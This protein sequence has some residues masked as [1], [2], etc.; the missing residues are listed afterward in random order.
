[1]EFS[2]TDRSHFQAAVGTVASLGDGSP[3]VDAEEGR[4]QIRAGGQGS[5]VLVEAVRRLDAAGVH[6]T[7]LAL[8]RPS[9]DDVFMS[10][11]GHVAED[12]VAAGAARGRRANKG[13]GGGDDGPG[14]R[15]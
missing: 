14:G 1:V 5:Q 4:V 8:R 11:T 9:L 10:L 2:V 7:G 6:T 12:V 13:S 15:H 3:V